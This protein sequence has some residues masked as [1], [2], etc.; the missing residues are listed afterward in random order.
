MNEQLGVYGCIG[1][2]AVRPVVIFGK[3]ISFI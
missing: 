1:L 2:Q 3:L